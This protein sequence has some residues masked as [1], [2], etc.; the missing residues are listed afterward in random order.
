MSVK[1]A[2]LFLTI[3]A[4]TALC[5]P[6]LA[7]N[8]IDPDPPSSACHRYWIYGAL[9][10]IGAA[11]FALDGELNTLSQDE[12]LHS[13][14]AD[15]VFTNVEVLGRHGPYYVGVP[16][17]LAEGLVFRDRRSLVAA[18]ELTA[19]LGLSEGITQIVKRSF[20][21]RRPS[22]SDSP[23]DFFKGGTSFYSGHT[24]SIF[25]FATI[26]AKSYP[27]QNLKV[28][29]IDR[30]FPLIPVLSYSL[31]VSVGLERLYDNKHWASDVYAGA[32]AGYAVG[33]LT[34]YLGKKIHID[35]WSVV[36]GRTPR[37]ALKFNLN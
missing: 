15:R 5:A 11:A 6:A 8:P 14:T 20:G 3:S 29:G 24:I 12:A 21:R 31:A 16:L 4:T 22:E 32:L 2:W 19:G 28:I 10:G 36:P 30:P 1:L 33:G 25:T 17:V 9:C 7:T 23:Y 26:L 13:E 35:S 27:R 34:V 37:I 18:G